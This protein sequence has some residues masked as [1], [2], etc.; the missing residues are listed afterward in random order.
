MTTTQ[1]YKEFEK[2]IGKI[3]EEMS[4]NL[5]K[6]ELGCIVEAGTMRTY[7]GTLVDV[8]YVYCRSHADD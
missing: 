7:E 2:V 8:L 3:I 5:D 1:M 4:K 6:Y